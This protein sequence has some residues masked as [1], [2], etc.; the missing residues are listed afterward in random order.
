MLGFRECTVQI[1]LL[2][3]LRGLLLLMTEIQ[4]IIIINRR[5]GQGF[6]ES[7]KVDK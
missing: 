1:C 2:W 7:L 5:E 3:E 6:H 4:T